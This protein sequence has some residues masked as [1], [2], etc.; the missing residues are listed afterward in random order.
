MDNLTFALV[1]SHFFFGWTI[2][3]CLTCAATG[4]VVELL[5]EA[6]FFYP[7]FAIT[8]RWKKDGVGK[9]YFDLRKKENC[10]ESFN[11]GNE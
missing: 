7:G 10:D 6:V 3:Q 8:R 5:C 11:N 9:E 1:V 4:M 2:V